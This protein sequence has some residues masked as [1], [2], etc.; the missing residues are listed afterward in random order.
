V[1]GYGVKGGRI[2]GKGGRIWG[3]GGRIWGLVSY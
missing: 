3:K 2:W 1:E